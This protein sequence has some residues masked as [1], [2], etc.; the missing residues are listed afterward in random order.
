MSTLKEIRK[1]IIS[2][3][4][5]QKI[6]HAMKMVSVAKF[7]RAQNAILKIRPYSNKIKNVL[8]QLAE[9]I[10]DLSHNQF[11]QKRELKKILLIVIT[12]D[13]GLCGSFNNSIIKETIKEINYYK[14]LNNPPGIDLI[15]IGKKGYDF[16]LRN[17]YK[18][19]ENCTD[20]SGTINV[21]EV[22]NICTKN[23]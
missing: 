14:K 21:W 7:K 13:K 11:Y 15:T 3:K 2:V 23:P 18:I 4:S 16:L 5:T 20:F 22:R 10:D 9:G 8:S 17:N 12:S 19:K 1:R 6:T